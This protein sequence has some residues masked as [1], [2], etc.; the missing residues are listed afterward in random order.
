MPELKTIK[1]Y[2]SSYED[3]KGKRIES[4]VIK[5]TSKREAQEIADGLWG[6][7]AEVKPLKEKGKK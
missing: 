1:K 7:D 5:A 6:D 3:E 2:V 4:V